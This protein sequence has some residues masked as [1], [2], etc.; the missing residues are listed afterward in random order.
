M[1]KS[2]SVE[3]KSKLERKRETDRKAQRASRAKTKAYIAF[4]EKQA[5]TFAETPDGNG[6]SNAALTQKL[7]AQWEENQKLRTT[8]QGINTLIKDVLDQESEET[9]GKLVEA[10]TQLSFCDPSGSSIQPYP[11]SEQ[12]DTQASPPLLPNGEDTTLIC[13]SDGT[14][15]FFTI[16]SQALEFMEILGADLPTPDAETDEDINIRA[17]LHGWDSIPE[18]NLDIGWKTM[19]LIDQGLFWR[20]GQVERIAVLR[21]QRSMFLV[22]A[23]P[24]SPHLP[25]SL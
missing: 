15:D 17:V 2:S 22:R 8:L 24:K 10:S 3:G 1:T 7:K 13:A 5:S 11:T 19:R 9:P 16:L 20:S 6:N 18:E 4:L 25:I 14:R 23:S 21:V 12:S